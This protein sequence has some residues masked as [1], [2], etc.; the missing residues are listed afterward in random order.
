MFDIGS[1]PNFQLKHS[2]QIRT[3]NRGSVFITKTS[4]LD[5]KRIR[6]YNKI[7]EQG[8]LKNIV[9]VCNRELEDPDQEPRIRI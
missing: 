4:D 1:N 6:I 2:F 7:W 3:K 9:H 5:Y 8:P